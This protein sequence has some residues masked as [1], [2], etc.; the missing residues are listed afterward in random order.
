MKEM[1]EKVKA[2]VDRVVKLFEDPDTL[3]EKLCISCFPASAIPSAQ[4]SFMN[5][6]IMMSHGTADARGVKQWNTVGRRINKGAKAFYILAP[7]M[8]TKTVDTL[9]G[10]EDRRVLIGFLY[11]PVFALED[12][13]GAELAEAEKLV[14]PRF[15]FMNVAEKWDI[16]VKPINGQRSYYGSYLPFSSGSGKKI[17][18]CTPNEQV[19]F[20]ELAHASHD[21]I[22]GCKGGQDAVQEIVAE[23]SSLVLMHY[24]GKKGDPRRTFDYVKRYATELDLDVHNACIKLI[25]KVA[26]VVDNIVSNCN[27]EVDQAVNS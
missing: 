3:P 12:T 11:V 13:N 7:R 2:E 26:K 27:E 19:F 6:L 10:T 16:D 18:L 17:E 15:D 9:Q 8:I 14:L 24:V 22:E 5:R 20:H 23:V 1:S 25:A 21:R 4:W